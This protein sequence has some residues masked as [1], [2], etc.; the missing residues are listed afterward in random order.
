MIVFPFILCACLLL[1]PHHV[2]RSQSTHL[3]VYH[4]SLYGS[5]CSPSFSVV[6][7][8][9]F[10]HGHHPWSRLY[11]DLIYFC[12]P[13]RSDSHSLTRSPSFYL[14]S[15]L[16]VLHV[17]RYLAEF[18]TFPIFYA[19]FLIYTFTL[20]LSRHF[21]SSLRAIFLRLYLSFYFTMCIISSPRLIP[22]F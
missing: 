20:S 17:E 13:S 4:L 8:C 1:A 2:S 19:S 18:R 10:I 21:G 14:S 7:P 6:P 22:L 3:S 11:I 5:D 9:F 12:S 16:S 15:Y